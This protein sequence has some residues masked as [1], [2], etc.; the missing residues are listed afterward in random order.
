MKT[1]AMRILE[2]AQIPYT[3]LSYN[4]DLDHLDALSAAKQLKLDPFQLFKTIVMR[5]NLQQ[6]YL[7]CIPGPTTISLKKARRV[8]GATTLELVEQEELRQLTG[9]VRG[10]VS[11]LGMTHP[12]PVLIDENVQINSQVAVSAGQR[13]L[14]ILLAV[15]DL[16]KITHGTFA[17][18]IT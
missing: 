14:Q 8:I 1:N 7:F 4:F 5:N 17:D 16:L 10:G 6:I 18:I 12:Y 3:V 9:Y 15:S 2:A 13:G 11:P